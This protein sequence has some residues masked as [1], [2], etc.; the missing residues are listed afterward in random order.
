[1]IDIKVKAK[2][3]IINLDTAVP[4]GLIITE[5]VTNSLKHAFTERENG[6]IIIEVQEITNSQYIL[7]IHDNGKG[8]PEGF[9]IPIEGSLGTE[10]VEVLTEQLEGVL[11]FEINNPG[12]YFKLHFEEVSVD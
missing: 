3:I 1:M 12:A 7:E 10:I 11:A 5:L 9:T 2:D 4:L 8:L 6:T